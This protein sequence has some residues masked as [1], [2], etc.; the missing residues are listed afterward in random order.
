[1]AFYQFRRY[2]PLNAML[3]AGCAGA[4]L[5]AYRTPWF[6]AVFVL[7][8]SYIIFYL[9]YLRSHFAI[10]YNRLGDYSY[11]MYIYAFPCAQIAAAL[12][13]GIS[14]LDLIAVSLPATLCCAVLSW[15]LVE[16]PALAHRV[17]IASWLERKLARIA[18]GR[19]WDG[20]SGRHSQL[21]QTEP[22]SP[23][24]ANHQ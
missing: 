23:S 3:A 9:G 6:D 22:G 16:S 7:S 13:K 4:A 2:V 10:I 11:G 21:T 5:L 18:V 17:V 20:L 15:H 1:M 19:V 12:W 14:P 24:V 8:W